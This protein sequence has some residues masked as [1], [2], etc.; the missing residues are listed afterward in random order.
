MFRSRYWATSGY[1]INPIT[2]RHKCNTQNIIV[3][4]V[5][6]RSI[7]VEHRSI[8]VG[9]RSI[10]TFLCDSTTVNSINFLWQTAASWCEGLPT[11]REMTPFPSSECWWFGSTKIVNFVMVSTLHT[12]CTRQSSGISDQWPFVFPF[13]RHRVQMPV[14]ESANPIY[15]FIGMYL[16]SYSKQHSPSWE[17]YV[18]V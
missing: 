4:Y 14:R 5:G 3:F 12:D 13:W 15:L 17:T 6:H 11:F 16:L 9:H 10:T 7:Y 2:K 8:Y 1:K 18:S